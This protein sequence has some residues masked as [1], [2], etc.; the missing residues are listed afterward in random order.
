M[1]VPTK[2]GNPNHDEEGKFTSE[3][4][5]GLKNTNDEELDLSIFGDDESNDEELD[6]GIFGDD[7]LDFD[8]DDMPEDSRFD[9]IEV[10]QNLAELSQEMIDYIDNLDFGE[11]EELII[12][13]YGDYFDKEKIFAATPEELKELV[14]AQ[15]LLKQKDKL[16]SANKE[17]NELNDPIF[18]NLWQKDVSA[19]DW[20]QKKENYYNKLDYFQNYYNKD[21]KE[22]KIAS[23][24]KFKELG[25]LYE[26]SYNELTSS[27]KDAEAIIDKFADKDAA[28]SKYRKDNAIWIKTG[29]DKVG[30]AQKIFGPVADKVVDKLNKENPEAYTAVEFYTDSYSIIQE[31]LR[32]TKYNGSKDTPF[33]WVKTIEKMSEAIDESTYDFDYWIAR[34][35]SHLKINDNLTLDGYTDIDVLKNLVGQTFEHQSFYS[36]GS[37]KGTGYGTARNIMI[38]TYCPKG[39][40]GLYVGNGISSHVSENEM[41]L[42]R[43]YSYRITKVEKHG[44]MIYLDV[45]CILGSDK[46]RYNH[47]ELKDIE[48]KYTKSY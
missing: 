36:A 43:G 37:A 9:D 27:F 4:K 1:K 14:K 41:I 34:S 39:T 47:D 23:L 7:D 2:S 38:N 26:Q 5:E 17:L 13:G 30:Q 19:A 29:K 22:Q 33:P 48:A 8:L 32:K 12:K 15:E 16:V 46:N 44:S 31:P 21:D 6:L 24:K 20:L 40:K 25:E 11:L 35:T 45:E 10:K 28:Y 42:Q 18:S 3:G